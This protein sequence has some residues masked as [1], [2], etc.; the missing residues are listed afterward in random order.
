MTFDLLAFLDRL[1]NDLHVRHMI[2]SAILSADDDPGKPSPSL[3]DLALRCVSAARNVDLSDLSRR[4]S[5]P[6]YVPDIWP[7]EH[8]KLLAGM[9]QTL[10]PNLVIE[11]GTAEGL[12]ALSLKKFLDPSSRIVTFD[13]VPWAEYPNH[14]LT[15]SDFEDGRLQQVIADLTDLSVARQY[16]SLLAEADIVFVDAA[17]DG[18]MEG[19]FLDNFSAVGLKEN[20]LIVFDD[21]RLI[22]MVPTWRQLT[23][24]KMD[25]TSFGHW[26]GTGLALWSRLS[27]WDKPSSRP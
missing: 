23:F 18:K 19:I 9:V 8:Y 14:A 2:P 21:I 27:P 16:A 13:I 3:I 17:K 11:I 22:Q 25:L 15:S 6:P 26:S 4:L 10:K 24:P 1:K 5:E 20:A 7:G 12:S